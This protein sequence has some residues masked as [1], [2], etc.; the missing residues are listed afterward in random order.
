MGMSGSRRQHEGDRTKPSNH[1]SLV[2]RSK[3]GSVN[4]KR[5]KSAV[6]YEKWRGLKWKWGERYFNNTLM[7]SDPKNAMQAKAKGTRQK[8]KQG[9]VMNNSF[10]GLNVQE[11]KKRNRIELPTHVQTAGR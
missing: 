7:K 6:V 3:R 4:Q 2:E 8:K 10:C 11:T 1:Q 5:K 9:K